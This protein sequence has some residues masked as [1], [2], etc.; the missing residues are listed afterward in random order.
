MQITLPVSFLKEGSS[1][2]AYT[3]ALDLSSCGK[4]L[5][6]AKKM[7]AESVQLFFEELEKMGTTEEV[8]TQ[9]FKNLLLCKTP[10]F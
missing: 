8:L 1:Y 3:P 5:K 10:A 9:C 7:F 4:T 6:E 2:V